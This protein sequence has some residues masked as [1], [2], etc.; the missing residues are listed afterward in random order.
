M[1]TDGTQT[2]DDVKLNPEKEQTPQTYTKEQVEK[3]VR[4]A[5]TAVQAD[6]GRMRTEADKALKA[7]QS[8][9]ERLLRLQKEQDD[10]ELDAAKDNP[11]IQTAIQ[12]RQ[13]RRQA[14]SDLQVAQDKLNETNSKL[15]ELS[16]KEKEVARERITHEIATRL[17]VDP[18]RL[19]KMAKFTDGSATEIEDIAKELPKLNPS[20]PRNTFRPDSNETVGGS[21]QS[22]TQIQEDYV[23]GKI[24][25]VQYSEKMKALGKTP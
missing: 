11:P 24:S 5:R 8:A 12:E 2:Q 19:V 4:D 25:N 6:V 10:R 20:P 22:V 18:A 1:E 23:K 9:S 13:R 17:N 14:E 21:P 3:L 16:N 7:A 15:Q